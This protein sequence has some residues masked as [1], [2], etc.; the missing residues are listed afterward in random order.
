MT[1]F[2]KLTWFLKG[3]LLQF[4]PLFLQAQ[5]GLNPGLL[6]PPAPSPQI[7]PIPPQMEAPGSQPLRPLGSPTAPPGPNQK[8]LLPE[9]NEASSEEPVQYDP[10]SEI[11]DFW[12]GWL[13]GPDFFPEDKMPIWFAVTP[14]IDRQMRNR[15]SQD[16]MNAERGEYNSWRETPRGRLALILLLDQFP[17]HIYRNKPQSFMLDRMAQALVMEGIQ[18]GDDKQLYPIERAFFYL[19]LEHS[20]DLN[21]QNLSVASYR[22]LFLDSPEPIRIQMQDFLQSAMMHQQQIA[23]FGRFPHRNA[24]LGRTSTPEE[25]VFLMQWRGR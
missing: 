12:F 11:L 20:E 16:V 24:V 8:P 18:K 14:E 7:I 10:S 19:P 21:L 17:R 9:S 1:G 22:Q 6:A 2:S 25:T 3:C 15:F 5:V 4:I 13:P 23:R